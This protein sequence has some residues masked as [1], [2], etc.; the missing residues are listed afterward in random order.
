MTIKMRFTVLLLLTTILYSCHKNIRYIEA[1]STLESN[2]NSTKQFPQDWLGYWE[3][4]LN[5]YNHTGKT[6]TIPM[7][8]DNASTDNDSIWTWAI[9]YGEDTIAGRRDYELNVVDASKGHYLIDEKNSILLDA[10]LL[11]N[12]LVS[13]FNVSGSVI[14]SSYELNGEEMLFSIQMY[15]EQSIRETGDTIS[16]GEEIPLVKSYQNKVWQ[17]ARLKKR[18]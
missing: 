18:K 3:G 4:E 1:P 13:T 12:S 14:Q 2:I 17:K 9:I 5:I 6:M 10:F 11:D 16:D 8:I 15:N 7:A